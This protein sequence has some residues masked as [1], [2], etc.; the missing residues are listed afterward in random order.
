MAGAGQSRRALAAKAAAVAPS[1]CPA[2]ATGPDPT[3]SGDGGVG[4]QAVLELVGDEAQVARLL[5]Q[6]ALVG[7]AG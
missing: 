7:G 4:G 2:S 3:E 1:D 5:L 6:V